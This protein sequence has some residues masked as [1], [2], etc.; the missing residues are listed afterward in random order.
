MERVSNMVYKHEDVQAKRGGQKNEQPVE[1]RALT[2]VKIGNRVSTCVAIPPWTR[3]EATRMEKDFTYDQD[4][5][6]CTKSLSQGQSAW[7]GRLLLN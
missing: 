4:E 5:E 7:I 1:E 3:T 6:P 2:N